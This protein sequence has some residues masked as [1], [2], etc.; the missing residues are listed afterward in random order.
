MYEG[1]HIIYTSCGYYGHVT[2]N[3][4]KKSMAQPSQSEN[5]IDDPSE[6]ATKNSNRPNFVIAAMHEGALVDIVSIHDTDLQ[7][8]D[9]LVKN[10]WNF[11]SLSPR[12]WTPPRNDFITLNMDGSSFGNSGMADYSG[13]LC[14]SVGG[15]IKGFII[16]IGISDNLHAELL[17]LW[18]GLRLTWDLGYRNFVCY[19]DSLDALLLI[20]NCLS[21]YH[22]YVAMVLGIRDCLNQ[23]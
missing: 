15:W 14:N 21:S 23:D 1:L 18:Y 6:V 8:K 20:H 2:K 16:S 19:S 5:V 12:S 11:D 10:T 9:V 7:V 13:F 22:H 4:R 17:A 3:C